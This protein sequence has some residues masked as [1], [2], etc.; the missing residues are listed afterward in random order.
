MDGGVTYSA[1]GF[2]LIQRVGHICGRKNGGGSFGVKLLKARD[3]ESTMDGA[4]RKRKRKS[5]RG[6]IIKD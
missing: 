3:E 1:G 5:R 4:V 2:E 6:G